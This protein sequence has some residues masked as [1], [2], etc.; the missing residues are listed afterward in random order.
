MSDD[1]LVIIDGQ[2]FEGWLT[3]DIDLKFE[4]GANECKLTMSEKPQGGLPFQKGSSLQI[5]IDGRPVITGHINS[6]RASGEWV[7]H[8]IEISGSDKSKDMVK[9]H[10]G[11]KNDF[12]API[13]LPD[14]LKKTIKNMGLDIPVTDRTGGLADF[15][16]GEVVSGDIVKRGFDFAEEWARK[17]Q[18]FVNP[19]GAGGL[20]IVRGDGEIGTGALIYRVPDLAGL[21]NVK[22]YQYEDTEDS[23]FHSQAMAAQ[24][25]PNDIKHFENLAKGDPSAVADEMANKYGHAVDSAVRPQLRR[26]FRGMQGA[27]GK[28]PDD[29]AQWHANIARARSFKY[30]AVVQG[31][32]QGEGAGELWWP[33]LLVPVINDDCDIN[34]V[35][36]VKGVHFKKDF[37]G[38]STTK[39]DCTYEDAYRAGAPEEPKSAGRTSKLGLGHVAPGSHKKVTREELGIVET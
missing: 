7:S 34:S 19:D 13:S 26:F 12:E 31:F 2:P 20:Q 3:I 9:S 23:T 14:V 38:G 32:H 30:E 25:S 27:Q 33:G 4:A 36:F 1:V 24:K 11:P 22:S 37:S 10:I 18:V 8:K 29:E 39:L 17:R 21:N 5:I 35:L 6:L 28:T 15:Q 16:R